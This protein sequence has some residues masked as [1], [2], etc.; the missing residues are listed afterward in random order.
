MQPKVA[1][2]VALALCAHAEP[3]NWPCSP[4]T[5]LLTEEVMKWD[6]VSSICSSHVKTLHCTSDIFISMHHASVVNI[7]YLN[8]KKCHGICMLALILRCSHFCTSQS[9]LSA[10]EHLFFFFILVFLQN[11]Y[12]FSVNHYKTK[13]QIFR[14]FMLCTYYSQAKWLLLMNHNTSKDLPRSPRLSCKVSARFAFCKVLNKKS[15]MQLFR[16][17]P[18]LMQNKNSLWKCSY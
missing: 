11:P 3:C 15:Q 17:N 9:H 8:H 10:K 4:Y 16:M 5:L 18:F 2:I 6:T 7:H 12:L 13:A 14:C 1:L